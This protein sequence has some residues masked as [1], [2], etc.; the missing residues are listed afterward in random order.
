MVG[1]AITRRLLSLGFSN[2]VASCHSRQPAPR[3]KGDS[4]RYIQIDLTRQSETEEFLG[5]VRPDYVFIAAAKVGGILANS[6]LPAEFIY[7]NMAIAAN[8]IHGSYLSGVKRLLNIGSS[9]IYPKRAPQPMKEDYLLAGAL[10]P[11][12]EA[13]AIA[14]IAAIKLCRYYNEQY[15]TD[16]ISAMPTNLYGPYD[17]FDLEK[18]H[19]I[20]AL[21][22]KFHLARL[23]DEGRYDL[24]RKDFLAWGNRCIGPLGLEIDTQTPVDDVCRALRHFGIYRTAD[25]DQSPSQHRTSSTIVRLWGTGDPQREFMHVDDLADACLF[26][27]ENCTLAEVREFVNVGTGTGIFI[28]ELAQL[29]AHTVGFKGAVT[30]DHTMP[31]G[32]PEKV[33]DVSR[34]TAWGWKPGI[35]LREGVAQ[36]YQWYRAV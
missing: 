6:T 23:L 26:L 33:M 13:Y 32:T 28:R 1:S 35:G 27:M 16:F 24:V 34:I 7:Q 17:N 8:V 36:M 5:Q 9:C 30:W 25:Q 15:G 3:Q 2:I 29:V 10:E 20:P 18:S 4:V 11:T 14:K 21:M 12:N 31:D 19:V 22:R